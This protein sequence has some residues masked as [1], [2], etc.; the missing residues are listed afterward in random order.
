MTQRHEFLP[1]AMEILL[2][3]DTAQIRAAAQGLLGRH[4]THL[5]WYIAAHRE[6]YDLIFR[7][8]GTAILI[9]RLWQDHVPPFRH[10]IVRIEMGFEDGH[11]TSI[12]KVARQGY[13]A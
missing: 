5:P 11:V 6:D 2:G 7:A 12:D 13:G 3:M 9:M 4:A 1:D 10:A 8:N